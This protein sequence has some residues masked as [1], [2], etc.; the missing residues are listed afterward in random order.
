MGKKIDVRNIIFGI[1][2][3][4]SLVM[5]V[6]MVFVSLLIGMAIFKQYENSI[7]K[8]MKRTGGTVL[9]GVID[10]TWSYLRLKRVL[11][12]INY[13]DKKNSQKKRIKKNYKESKKRMKSYLASVIKKEKILDIAFLIDINWKDFNFNPKKRKNTQY[14]YFDKYSGSLFVIDTSKK[15]QKNYNFTSRDGKYDENLETTVYTH[16]MNNIDISPFQTTAKARKGSKEK[17][18]I[19]GVPVF[20]NHSKDLKLYKNYLQFKNKEA[21]NKKEIILSKKLKKY[22]KNLFLNRIIKNE[23]DIDY[24]LKLTKRKKR[25]PLS[26][27]YKNYETKRLTRIQK[28]ELKKE[29]YEVLNSKISDNHINISE[30]NNILLT[31]QRKYN[32]P[33][34]KKIKTK[35]IDKLFYN[36]IKYKKIKISSEKTLDQLAL[37]SFRKDIVGII[38]TYL[39][40]KLVYSEMEKN[41]DSIINLIISILIRSIFVALFFPTFII[42]SIKTLGRGAYEIGK[43]DFD[44]KIE[45][46]GSDELG[47]LADIINIMTGNLRE[48]EKE[49]I[50]KMRMEN[51]LKTAQ[52]IQ[53]ALLPENFPELP[54][55]S[56]GSYYS[57]QSESGG[58]Y[59]DF[60]DLEDNKLGI[61]IADVSGHGVGSG[62]VMAMTRTLLH[63]FCKKTENT[64][65]IMKNIN[66]YLK[67][68]TA[69]NYFVTMFYGILDL[70]KMKLTYTSAGHNPVLILRDGKINELEAGGIALGATGNEMFSKL[71]KINEVSLMKN[72]IIIQTTDG[73]DE[74]M[75]SK[76]EEFGTER[77]NKAI[78]KN[79]GKSPQELINGVIDEL[80]NFTG[81]IEQHDDITIIAV[82]IK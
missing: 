74:A 61:T 66:S 79:T 55:I 17:F 9:K 34:K 59:Y 47:R 1:R 53:E 78:L 82:E 36:Y 60:I 40:R 68:N 77:L 54:A 44:R 2:L 48:A 25:Y 73:I 56:Y 3:K 57:A 24:K 21:S 46:S 67:E 12:S 18:V 39:N 72:D 71:S 16:F 28:K 50:V 69:S 51:E 5:I 7:Q 14:K 43:G 6:S 29:Y 80:N 13:A 65:A 32:T 27:F 42:R 49:K 22:Y 41:R 19:I 11:N 62:L 23:I 64:N 81:N 26:F 20:Y 70:N 58:D 10:N 8:E 35:K 38:G 30:L 33:L 76:D 4:F 45:L 52:M 63:V 37:A 31:I 75:N 15:N